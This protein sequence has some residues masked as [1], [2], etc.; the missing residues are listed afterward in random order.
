MRAPLLGVCLAT[1][2]ERLEAF[3]QA[4]SR[5]THR[6]AR[7]EQGAL[8]IALAAA[9]GARH[10][11]KGVDAEAFLREL[12]TRLDEPKLREALAT[13][14]ACWRRGASTAEL[15]AELGLERGVSGYVLHTVP[16][17]LHAWL[18]H[19]ADFRRAVEEVILLGGDTDTTGAIAGGLVGATVGLRGIPP[20][21]LS[22]LA[23]W[24]RTAQWLLRLADRLAAQFPEEGM[25][26]R[27]G[28]LPL[29]W[30]GLLPRNL[31]MLALV[32]MHGFR[33]ALPPY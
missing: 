13:V 27:P 26:Q 8:A 7:A 9:H 6:D 25:P 12:D 23:E 32:L 24:P 31:A 14:G 19:A 15:A 11:A 5:L 20:E 18:R 1:Q 10:G 2:P 4:S 29:F 16:V 30:P 3:V 28:P 17:V 33:R 22:G 21:W